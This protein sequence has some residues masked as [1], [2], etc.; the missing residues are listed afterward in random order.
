MNAHETKIV[1]DAE[2]EEYKCV[3]CETYFAYQLGYR[4]C[5]YCNRKII[6]SDERGAKSSTGKRCGVIVK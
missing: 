1:W 6:H 3:A 5:P 4:F 2:Y